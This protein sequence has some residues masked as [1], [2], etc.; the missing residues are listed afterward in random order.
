MG[1]R[2]HFLP[3]AASIIVLACGLAFAQKEAPLNVTKAD[4][5][6]PALTLSALAAQARALSPE[7]RAFADWQISQG[8]QKLNDANEE[9][10][11][12]DVFNAT[13]Q[14]EP[15]D[16]ELR[17]MQSDLQ[18]KAML[19]LVTLDP[20]KAD[21]LKPLA[22]PRVQASLDSYLVGK[23]I[24]N[25]DFEAAMSSMDALSVS[26]HFPFRNA[27]VLMDAIPDPLQK[28]RVFADA[29]RGYRSKAGMEQPDGDDLATLVIRHWK[30]L[31]R[32]LISE[33]IDEIIKGSKKK[34][35]GLNP[36]L[37]VTVGTPTGNASFSSVYKFRL[38]ELLPVMK[39]I[40]PIAAQNLLDE[41]PALADA[42]SRFPKGLA[43]LDSSYSLSDPTKDRTIT[44]MYR[45][46][47]SADQSPPSYVPPDNTMRDKI[48]AIIGSGGSDP[49][50]ALAAAEK[51]PADLQGGISP[52]AEAF[53]GIGFALVIKD[54]EISQTAAGM[55][56]KTAMGLPPLARCRYLMNAMGIYLRINDNQDAGD[57]L[58]DGVKAAR[59]LYDEDTN[60]NDPNLAVK[61]LW[62]ST[63]AF[64]TVAFAAGTISQSLAEQVI[65]ES[66][67]PDVQLLQRITLV[68]QGLKLP[69][70][71]DLIV[72]YKKDSSK[73]IREMFYQSFN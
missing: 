1:I 29:I 50:G 57:V 21:E 4:G 68:N 46:K 52:R 47:D 27:S 19:R 38:F 73:F 51:L 59:A 43:S 71:A 25:K 36:E 62:P 26:D 65:T 40:D 58:G 28:R 54:P 2:S 17:S 15:K 60:K 8:L 23:Q 55:L 30:T 16:T 48:R 72:E 53:R 9:D 69:V 22:Q 7:M 12:I 3:H 6:D 24:A 41:E 70:P 33:A 67:D 18:S 63:A 64:R 32:P 5:N 11:L 13:K 66:P 10:L 44:F 45:F 56:R 35:D 61:P 20:K 49:K 31:P 34:H 14:I 39:E 37:L 42:L